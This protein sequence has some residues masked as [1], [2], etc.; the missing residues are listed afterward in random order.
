MITKKRVKISDLRADWNYPTEIRFGIGRI[1]ELPETC[2]ALGMRAP[3]LV[4]D[5]SIARLPFIEEFIE[6]NRIAGIDTQL[7]SGITPDPDLACIRKGARFYREKRF[8]GIISIGGG[9]ALDAG[10]AIALA[11]AVGPTALCKYVFGNTI[12]HRTNRKINAIISIPTTAGT[13]SEVDAHALI[14]DADTHRKM[15]IYHPKLLPRIVIAD[16]LLT[17]TLAPPMTAATGFDALSH[18]LEA[19]CSPAFNPVLDSIASQGIA[20]IKDWLPIAV[21][22]QRSLQARVY[23]M[24][25]SIMGAIAFGKGLGAMHAL[26]HS[27]GAFYKLHHGRTIAAVMPYVLKFNRRQIS[28]KMGLLAHFLDLRHADFHA[29]LNWILDLRSELGAPS[30]L[31]E[32]GVRDDHIPSLAQKAMED[33]NVGTNPAPLDQHKMEK[34]LSHAI[35]GRL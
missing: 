25:A 19:L 23:T 15:S 22:E 6:L 31:G 28:D 12:P 9:S 32:L 30:C 1:R 2:N 21:Q 13:G 5:P 18:N 24:A 11:A 4:T 7:F 10:K 16:P 14:T 27:V 26:A 34:L 20:Y 35:Q 17:R 33:P 8:D 3:L 29:V